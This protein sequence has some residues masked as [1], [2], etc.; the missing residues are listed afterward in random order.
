MNITLQEMAGKMREY[1][2]YRIYYHKSPDG[3]AVMSA[4]AL[5]AALQSIGKVCEPVCSD[6]VPEE[7]LDM[8]ADFQFSPVQNYT[9]IAVDSADKKRLG[10]Y[11]EEKITLCVD[12][13]ENRMEADY[14]YVVPE[15]SSC[16]E[17]VYRLILEMGISVTPKLAELLY[18]GLVTDTQCFRTYSTNTASLETA[19]AL[20][21]YGVNIVAIARRFTLEKTPERIAIER[22]LLD[23]FRYTCDDRILGCMVSHDDLVRIGAVDSRLEGL[24]L[25][26][27]Q[28][29][30]P[31]IGI[32]VRETQPGHCRISVRT[33]TGLN[34]A[35]IC[36]S[37][38]GGGHADRAG[39]EIEASPAEAM[40]RVEIAAAA[41]INK[42]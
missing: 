42:H 3:D 33:Y 34:A 19:A 8:I 24:N 18:T 28:V 39:G 9:A 17:L 6:P 27:D 11:A 13:H 29:R 41:Y 32:V 26:V 12:H 23:S 15:A 31:E 40:K 20:A 35:E 4:Y 10:I 7:Y 22:I 2:T 1:N 25:I 36:A 16:C 30:G 37:F 14:K 21:G 5:A 38:G